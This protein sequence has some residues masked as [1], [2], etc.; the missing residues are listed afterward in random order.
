MDNKFMLEALR[1]A[2]K[3]LEIDE[4]PVGCVIVKDNKII[5]RAHNIK[6]K[7]NNPAGHAELLAIQKACKKLDNWRLNDCELY[8]TLEP[9]LMCCG[10]IVQSRIKR[11]YYG[12]KDEK[13]G[14]VESIAYTFDL[15]GLNHHVSYEGQVLEKECQKLLS[16]Y[17]KSKRKKI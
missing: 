10:A 2:N 3:A 14:G 4:V 12:A 15:Q 9:C 5:A 11:V 6:E 13:A 8:V 17:F 7:T 1:E 16:D